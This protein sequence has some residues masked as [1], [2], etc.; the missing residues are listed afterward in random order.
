MNCAF[1]LSSLRFLGSRK[2]PMPALDASHELVERSR[3]G[4]PW[5]HAAFHSLR[6]G[7]GLFQF[8]RLEI[9]VLASPLHGAMEPMP[10]YI[11]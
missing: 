8:M 3:R 9:P 5:R 10:R 1:D 7:F 4:G 2:Y 6:H 11:L